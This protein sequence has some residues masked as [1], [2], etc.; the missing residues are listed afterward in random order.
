M[1]LHSEDERVLTNL[2]VLSA[3]SHADKLNTQEDVFD[4]YPPTSLR[5]LVRMW[6]GER[7]GQ[8]VVRV[9]QTLFTAMVSAQKSLEEVHSLRGNGALDTSMK[10][11]VDRLALQHL[12][13]VNAMKCSCNGLRNL[14]ETYKTD[15]ALA[16]QITLL[17]GEVEDFVGLIS[18]HS[19]NVSPHASPGPAPTA[20]PPIP[21]PL[22]LDDAR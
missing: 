18:P 8:N 14:L 17:I 21:S 3:L 15:P 19:E 4:I 16:S 7:R 2:S 6:Y 20:L 22:V 9:R 12:R 5:G 1:S 13:M 11:R 10:I